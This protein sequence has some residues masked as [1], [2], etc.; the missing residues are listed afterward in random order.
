MNSCRPGRISICIAAS[1]RTPT[2]EANDVADVLQ[3]VYVVAAGSAQHRVGVPTPN[4]HGADERRLAAHLVHRLGARD[5]LAA[6]QSMVF[7]PVIAIA[8]VIENVHAITIVAQPKPQAELPDA[9]RDDIGAAYEQG[10]REPFVHRGLRRAQHALILT[11]GI[12]DA[13]RCVL[14][15][16]EHR[17]HRRS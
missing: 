16:G 3:V 10:T 17:L 8:R 7:H 5:T 13:L 2:T 4:Q 15:R 11:F 14:G 1:V 6:H 9:G 12:D